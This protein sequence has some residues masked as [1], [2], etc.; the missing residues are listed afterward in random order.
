MSNDFHC[1]HD[2]F[3]N[4]NNINYQIPEK[5]EVVTYEDVSQVVRKR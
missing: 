3:F 4:V 5:C 1:E 2:F